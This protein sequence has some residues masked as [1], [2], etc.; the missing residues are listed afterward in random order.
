METPHRLLITAEEATAQH[1]K[2]N[3][4]EACPGLH[5]Q[6]GGGRALWLPRM[7]MSPGAWPVPGGGGVPP[8]QAPLPWLSPLSSPQAGRAGISSTDTW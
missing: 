5:Q 4:A 2:A 7:P 3:K 1:N 6:H 8:G